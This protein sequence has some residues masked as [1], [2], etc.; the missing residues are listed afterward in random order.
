MSEKPQLTR[1][2]AS[3][4]QSSARNVGEPVS[5]SLGLEE[6]DETD[7]SGEEGVDDIYLQT[8]IS[9]LVDRIEKIEEKFMK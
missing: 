6:E 5:A 8:L 4:A 2:N 7:V 3:L 9:D 1:Q